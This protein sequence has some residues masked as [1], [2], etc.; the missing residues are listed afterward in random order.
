MSTRYMLGG[1][2]YT[3]RKLARLLEEDPS[4][5]REVASALRHPKTMYPEDT[6]EALQDIEDRLYREDTSDVTRRDRLAAACRAL[7]DA[8]AEHSQTGRS[9]AVHRMGLEDAL[10]DMCS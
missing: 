5:A 7:A 8:I 9:L 1:T 10:R 2:G 6:V 4:S 3:A